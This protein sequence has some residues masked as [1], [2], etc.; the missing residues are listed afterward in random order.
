[1]PV[2][3]PD[4]C[5]DAI[6]TGRDGR[7]WAVV[8]GLLYSFGPAGVIQVTHGPVRPSP[9]DAVAIRL[10]RGEAPDAVPL[11]KPSLALDRDGR[12]LILTDDVLLGV[13]D[14]GA[15]VVLGQDDRLWS[16]TLVT[17]EDGPAVRTA[18]ATTHRL[19]Y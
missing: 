2:S 1:V 13:T 18:D 9:D 5:W 6:V 15:V 4:G 11:H 8:D 3:N 16:M 10:A 19:G 7:G 12:P 14:Q 17:T